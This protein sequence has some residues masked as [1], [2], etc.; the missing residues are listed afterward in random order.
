M[1]QQELWH[2][3]EALYFLGIFH[4]VP[5]VLNTFFRAKHRIFRQDEQDF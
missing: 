3:S 1:M 4:I 2:L 5:K